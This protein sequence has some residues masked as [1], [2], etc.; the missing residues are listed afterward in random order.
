MRWVLAKSKRLNLLGC[1]FCLQ[2]DLGS[3]SSVRLMSATA[4]NGSV[5]MNLVGL[6]F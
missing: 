3:V 4:D 6:F 2:G 1:R 5:A